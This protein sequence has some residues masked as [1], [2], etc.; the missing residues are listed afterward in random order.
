MN[1]ASFTQSAAVKAGSTSQTIYLV[2]AFTAQSSPA[3]GTV[4]LS[5][6][7]QGILTFTSGGNSGLS[8]TIASY[9]ADGSVTLDTQTLAAPQAGDTFTVVYGC[10]RT[11]VACNL[12]LGPTNY[13]KHYPGSPYVPWPE[14]IM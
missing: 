10:D 9:N 12:Y 13:P 8:Y 1:L 2:A 14:T 3:G 7:A 4:P 5:R 6:L 11:Q